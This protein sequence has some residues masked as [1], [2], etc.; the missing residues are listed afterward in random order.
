VIKRTKTLQFLQRAWLWLRCGLEPVRLFPQGP[1]DVRAGRAGAAGAADGA[2]RG[3]NGLA[4]P[5]LRRVRDRRPARQRPGRGGAA[6]PPGR[7]AA[8]RA[9][10]ARVRGGAVPPLPGHRRRGLRV[11]RFKYDRAGIQ[12]AYD[13]ALPAIRTLYRDLG[14]DVN[15]KLFRL[16]NESFTFNSRW[17]TLL[18]IGLA[19]YA[20]IELVE[21]IGLWLGQR[22]GEY[23]AMV[24]TSIFL[25]WEVYELTGKNPTWLK[26]A[27]F[28][29]NLLLVVYLVWTRRLFGVRGGKE[30]Y[31]ARL[32]SE[33]VIEVEQ[34]ALA[35]AAPGQP[36]HGK[37]AS[38]AIQPEPPGAVPAPARNTASPARTTQSGP[39]RSG[40]P[41]R[42]AP[43]TR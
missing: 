43:P 18:S 31:E 30:A 32:R 41:E 8:Q 35:A 16:I 2:D 21:S 10:A 1:H 38:T 27:A 28:A 23:F 12:R 24:A 42:T 36:G 33:S 14:F 17:L 25:P 19:V 29:I 6:D 20:L 37:P 26:V 13:N 4:V 39:V 11:W 22:W 34:A 9:D 7:R 5:A 40:T 15:S 3:R